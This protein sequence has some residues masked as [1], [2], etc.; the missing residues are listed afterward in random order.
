MI[1]GV[2]TLFG[3][4]LAWLLGADPRRLALVRL[5]ASWVVFVAL[6]VQLVLF[7][8]ASQV[9]H[10]PA[11]ETTAHIVTYGALLAFVVAN[12]AQPGFAIAALGCNFN[13]LVIVV[14]DGHMPV[15]LASWTA[16]GRSAEELT[17][18]GVYNNVVLA[19][20]ANLGWLGD[21]FPLPR[22]VPLANSLSI[23]D[24]PVPHG[25]PPITPHIVGAFGKEIETMP[26]LVA[27]DETLSPLARAW[28]AAT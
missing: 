22:M 3:V 15:S 23:G 19:H 11:S 4:L 27:L 6:A 28:V 14:N 8:S 13:A 20:H 26:E 24:L 17:R 21:V 10:L 1:L 16:T 9:L 7:T 5:R 12:I 18:D 25:A 2:L